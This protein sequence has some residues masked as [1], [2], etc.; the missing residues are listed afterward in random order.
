MYFDKDIYALELH[1]MAISPDT[2]TQAMRVPGGWIY[3]NYHA[4]ANQ[5]TETFVPFCE[6][7]RWGEWVKRP[8]GYWV[9]HPTP[10]ST[11]LPPPPQTADKEE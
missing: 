11:P 3:G 1:E 6:A 5:V 2:N 7:T 10:P 8:D 9:L 4:G